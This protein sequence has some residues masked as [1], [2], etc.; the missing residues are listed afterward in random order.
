MIIALVRAMWTA[1]SHCEVRWSIQGW[2]LGGLIGKADRDLIE[3][4]PRPILRLTRRPADVNKAGDA[5]MRRQAE[6]IEHT[7]VVGVPFGDPVCPVAEGVSGEDETHGRGAGG[8]DLLPFGDFHMRAGAAH[9]GDHERRARE[10][11]ALGLDMFRLCIGVLSAK[12]SDDCLAGRTP[13]FAF[14]HDET[15]RRQ[16]AVIGHP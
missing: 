9:H 16:L 3:W 15:P 14:K 5:L 8:E 6:S 4:W 2:C 13:S 10:T 11:L 12:S 7:A 1:T